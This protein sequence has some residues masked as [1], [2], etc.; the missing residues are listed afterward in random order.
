[1]MYYYLEG[2]YSALTKFFSSGLTWTETPQPRT[3]DVDAV[4]YFT[5]SF[6]AE[7]PHD[8]NLLSIGIFAK[9]HLLDGKVVRKI[10]RSGSPEDKL[11]ISRESHIYKLLGD[12]PR[13][14]Q[15]LFGSDDLVDIQYYPNGNLMDYIREHHNSVS[16]PVRLNWFRQ[17]IEAVVKIHA[18]GVIHSD[19]ALRQFFLDDNMDVRLGDF[20]S[21]QWPGEMALGYEK[22]SHCLPRDYE[23]PNTVAS[24][25]FAL[26]ST[27]YELMT[28][29]VPH[30]DLLPVESED[31][32]KSNDL[33]VIQGRILREEKADLAIEELFVKQ[34][35]PDVSNLPGGD[36]ILKCWRC[37]FSTAQDVL[38]QYQQLQ[39][40]FDSQA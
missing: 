25:L 2:V 26:G 40:I 10:P 22:A 16:L 20:N 19:L 17:I 31:I 4:Q 18:H 35:F 29:T 11:P 7:R 38:E 37:Q 34:V 3:N 30:C 14:A 6:V 8:H 39:I 36:I 13:I 28:G 1:M 23:Q 21:S 24:D 15:C 27:L 33:S 5:A 9:V 12:H 32:L